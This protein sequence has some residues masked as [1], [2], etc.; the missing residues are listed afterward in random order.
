MSNLE[1]QGI[2]T[3]P[4]CTNLGQRSVDPSI[5]PE[6]VDNMDAD[7]ADESTEPAT[8]DIGQTPY[9]PDDEAPAKT[10]TPIG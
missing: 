2:P 7:M 4:V 8:K 5:M 1:N 10:A 9:G 3:N 6:D